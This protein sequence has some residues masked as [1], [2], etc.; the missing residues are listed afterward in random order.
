MWYINLIKRFRSEPLCDFN[1]V[2]LGTSAQG[3][4]GVLTSKLNSGRGKWPS[5]ALVQ[6]GCQISLMIPRLILLKSHEVEFE[7]HEVQR[8]WY[9]ASTE[10]SEWYSASNESAKISIGS[11]NLVRFGL[12]SHA[13]V[14]SKSFNYI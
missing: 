3:Q 14:R 6:F 10:R 13:F 9:S 8:S 2:N 1:K 7:Y 5:P 12:K 4:S 11:A